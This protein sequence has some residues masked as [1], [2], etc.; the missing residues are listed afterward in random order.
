MKAESECT[1]VSKDRVDTARR[2][3]SA[4]AI[5]LIVSVDNR[6]APIC[7][8]AT[9]VCPDSLCSTATPEPK[10]R[11][12]LTLSPPHHWLSLS[13]ARETFSGS[14][15]CEVL[16]AQEGHCECRARGLHPSPSKSQ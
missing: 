5:Y 1:A 2:F 15:P 9:A 7:R 12:L 8:V 4:S 16:V 13:C 3:L 14:L 10:L 6:P 11:R